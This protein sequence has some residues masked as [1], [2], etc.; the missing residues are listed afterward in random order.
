MEGVEA[1]RAYGERL[2]VYAGLNPGDLIASGSPQSGISIVVSRDGQRRAQ[3]KAEPVNRDGDAQLLATAARLANAYGGASLPTD[4]RA[5]SVQYAQLGLSQQERKIQ[6]ENLKNETALG[7]VSRVTMARRLNPGIDSDEEA[8]TFLVDQQLQEQRLAEA[9]AETIEP[10]ED[11]PGAVAE[12]GAARE[13]LR[14]GAV[15][16]AALDEALLAI[17]AELGGEDDQPAI[18]DREE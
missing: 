16:V 17:L 2:A 3:S 6:I 13:M 5:Y 9:L 8:I 10:E 11:I 4:E 7:L 14:G 15:D 12:I 18:E 1:L